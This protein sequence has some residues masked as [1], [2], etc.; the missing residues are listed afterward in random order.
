MEEFKTL[1]VVA[2]SAL[3]AFLAP[4]S[5]VIYSVILIASLNFAVGLYVARKVMNEPFSFKKAWECIREAAIFF[6]IIAC[7]LFVG[8]NIDKPD[9][10]INAILTVTIALLYFYSVN[11]FK[12]LKRWHPKSRWIAFVYLIISIEFVKDV[13]FMES[14]QKKEKEGGDGEY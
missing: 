13:P 2:L 7:A 4:I 5:G 3:A 12:N 6:V 1:I 9:G 14:F 11:I 8:K 10:A